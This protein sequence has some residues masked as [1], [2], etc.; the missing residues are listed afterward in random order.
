MRRWPALRGALPCALL[1]AACAAADRPFAD[2][3]CRGPHEVREAGSAAIQAFVHERRMTVASFFGY[4]GAGYED[5]VAMRAQAA[6]LLD[7][8]DPRRTL[9]NAGATEVGIGAVY[10]IAKRK[11]FTTAGIVSSLARDERVPLSP[12]VDH[13]FFVPDT[14]WGGRL[15]GSDRLAPTSEAIVATS[16]LFFAIGGGEI[17]RDELLAAQR[18]GKPVHFVPADLDHRVARERARQRGQPE[19]TDFRGAAHA[20]LAPP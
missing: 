5:P 9:V 20:A 15:P 2:P 1:L 17:A 16:E 11:G 4:S 13:V 10:E 14:L 6:R 12:C 7:T 19:P 18:A 8:L 3:A